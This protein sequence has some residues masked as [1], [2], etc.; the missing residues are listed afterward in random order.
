M[1]VWLICPAYGDDTP[2][3]GIVTVTGLRAGEACDTGVNGSRADTFL[4]VTVTV[5]GANGGERPETLILK[6][7]LR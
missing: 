7:W 4:T 5:T 1:V 6:I 3:E 2:R